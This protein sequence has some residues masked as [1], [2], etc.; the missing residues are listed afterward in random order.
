MFSLP[1][2]FM[3]DVLLVFHMHMF[4]KELKIIIYQISN[5]E[6]RMKPFDEHKTFC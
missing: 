6:T 2:P 4:L 3:T 5:L 1:T